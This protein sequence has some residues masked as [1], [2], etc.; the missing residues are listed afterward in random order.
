[1]DQKLSGMSCLPTTSPAKDGTPLPRQADPAASAVKDCCGLPGWD[2]C[3]CDPT[4]VAAFTASALRLFARP[5]MCRP[6]SQW[7]AA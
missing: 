5:I 4:E 2:E 7:G 6:A 3:G 1:M